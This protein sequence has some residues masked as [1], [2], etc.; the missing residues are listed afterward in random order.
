MDKQDP[1][2]NQLTGCL[3]RLFWMGVGNLILALAAIAIAQNQSGPFVTGV[4]GLGDASIVAREPLF[5][6]TC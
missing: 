4:S 2:A 3:V 5:G 1:K 6:G